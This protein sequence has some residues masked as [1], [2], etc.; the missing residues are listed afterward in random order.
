MT[1]GAACSVSTSVPDQPTDR[2]AMVTCLL[3]AE[4]GAGCRSWSAASGIRIVANG[5][6][7][8]ALAHARCRG[9][10]QLEESP[11][12]SRVVMPKPIATGCERSSTSRESYCRQTCSRR[13][14]PRGSRGHHRPDDRRSDAHW[15]LGGRDVLPCHAL[16]SYMN[17]RVV[18]CA[19]AKVAP[20]LS[21][22]APPPRK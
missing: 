13:N 3:Q 10:W 20:P 6:G 14:S 18:R 17:F 7:T 15:R 9:C 22:V 1:R 11:K 16:H 12:S 4:R 19:S 8:K 5:H 2:W 21:K